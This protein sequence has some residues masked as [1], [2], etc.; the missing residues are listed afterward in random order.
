MPRPRTV[1]FDHL[2]SPR[3]TR[4]SSGHDFRNSTY[5]GRASSLGGFRNIAGP[6]EDLGDIDP[7]AYIDYT[8]GGQDQ[9]SSPQ[10]AISPPPALVRENSIPPR[11]SPTPIRSPVRDTT[12]RARS[13]TAL[14]APN[15]A[16][17]EYY[18]AR[19]SPKAVKGQ[20]SRKK[21]RGPDPIDDQFDAPDPLDMGGGYEYEESDDMDA[22]SPTRGPEPLED[23]N[24]DRRKPTRETEGSEDDGENDT[25]LAKK[26]LKEKQAKSEKA[27]AKV[28]KKASKKRAREDDQENEEPKKKKVPTSKASS[29]P[30]SK[31]DPAPDQSY[32]EGT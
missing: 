15:G 30:R 14:R 26:K 28:P 16:T 18:S 11:R 31:A 25:P 23:H 27:K 5:L 1:D 6:P 13:S 3:T 21:A 9:P 20:S 8:G 7:D 12:P 19:E 10:A 22:G 2:P 4:N 24:R 17:D 29:K 32:F